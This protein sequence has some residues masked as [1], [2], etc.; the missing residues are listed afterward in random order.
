MKSD[1]D[2]ENSY[3]VN[4]E[5]HILSLSTHKDIEPVDEGP[6]DRYITELSQ[7]LEGKDQVSRVDTKKQTSSKTKAHTS[8]A[9]SEYVGKDTSNSLQKKNTMAGSSITGN[10]SPMKM[11]QTVSIS[12]PFLASNKPLNQL[13]CAA[14]FEF[15]DKPEGSGMKLDYLNWRKAI[16]FKQQFDEKLEEQDQEENFIDRLAPK[17]KEGDRNLDYDQEW[18]T[19]TNKVPIP[20]K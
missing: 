2:A 13:E 15:M 3:T 4:L 12:P 14:V 8:G 18:L 16:L 10:V 17:F 19:K 7:I 20:H 1:L 6:N 5:D 11:S 9:G